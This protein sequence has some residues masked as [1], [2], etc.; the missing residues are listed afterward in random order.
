MEGSVYKIYERVKMFI[1]G[2]ER[3]VMACRVFY[4][5]HAAEMCLSYL[6]DRRV[7]V[8]LVIEQD[9]GM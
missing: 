7:D 3:E 4:S 9:G 8:K 2:K 1:G 6:Q 5:R